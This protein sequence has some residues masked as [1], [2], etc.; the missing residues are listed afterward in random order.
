MK[1]IEKYK[2][3]K[4]PN[5]G[6]YH[7]YN[8]I[9]KKNIMIGDLEK[10]WINELAK[11]KDFNISDVYNIVGDEYYL[12]FL[13]ALEKFELIDKMQV[14]KKILKKFNIFKLMWCFNLCITEKL[15]S[16]KLCEIFEII[17]FKFTP[18]LGIFTLFSIMLK[19]NDILV[20]I[21]S[22]HFNIS[23]IVIWIITVFISGSLHEISHA[24]I[25]KNRNVSVPDCGVMLLIFN[26][27]FFVDLSGIAFL[28]NLKDFFKIMISGIVMNLFLLFIG[29]VMFIY[30]PF[31]KLA[32]I[33]ILVNFLMAIINIIPFFEYD[34]GIIFQKLLEHQ[35]NVK[36]FKI[37]KFMQLL[38]VY[39][40]ILFTCFGLEN[41]LSF[42]DNNYEQ[43]I[44]PFI[45]SGLLTYLFNR[46]GEK[47]VIS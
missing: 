2:I 5:E 30:T 13:N 27:S 17:L 20:R 41:Y 14:K 28:N 8:T 9:N 32:E 26:P 19:N 38:I 11:F 6:I 36:Y 18:I 10:N 39:S 4:T 31:I 22:F 1:I 37:I 44:L 25:A 40:I 12:D 42:I 35:N 7:L 47:N 21:N 24:I 16:K 33:I 29:V 34:G 45:I 46:N 3:L 23:Y 43:V 15:N